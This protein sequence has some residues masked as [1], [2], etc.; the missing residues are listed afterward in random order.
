MK[1][2]EVGSVRTASEEAEC[3]G[4]G[5]LSTSLVANDGHQTGVEWQVDA[6]KPRLFKVG[7]LPVGKRKGLVA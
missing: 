1:K 4:Q 2:R 7:V 6:V 5:A 3:L